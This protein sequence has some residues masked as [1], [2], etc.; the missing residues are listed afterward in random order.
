MFARSIAIMFASWLP[1]L[2]LALPLGP[3]HR[4]N[5]LVCGFAVLVLSWFAL[6]FHRARVAAAVIAAWVAA[7]SIVFWS[8]PLEAV[9][10]VTWGVVIFFGM[11]G[12]FS[13]EIESK[14][15]QPAVPQ[16]TIAREHDRRLDHAA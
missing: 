13:A 9:V 2:A 8:S 10:T 16:E 6:S 12:P 7:S 4:I 5:A 15:R 3:A 1:L 14:G 11:L